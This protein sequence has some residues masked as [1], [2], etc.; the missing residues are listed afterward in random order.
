MAQIIKLR[1]SSVSGQKPTNSNLELGELA[2]NTTDG[3]V[4]LAKSGS[5]QSVEELISTNASNTGSI[6]LSGSINLNGNQIISGTLSLTRGLNA[7]SLTGS[8]NYE[9]LTNVPTLVS[10]SSQISYSGLTEIPLGIVSGSSQIN[11][12][13]TTGYSTLTASYV[14]NAVSSSFA[15][16]SENAIT[17]SYVLNVVS[18]SFAQN[19]ENAVSSS[20]AQNSVTASYV[21]NAVSSSFTQNS[22]NAV[23]SSF[24][25]NSENAITASYVLNVVSSSFSTTA[26]NAV[27]ASYVLNAVS[28]SFTQNSENAVSSSFAQNSENAVS[29][30]FAQN[31]ENTVTA[32][33]A[34]TAKTA[35]NAATTGSNIFIGNQTISGSVSVTGNINASSLTGSI[36]YEN[37]TNVP[38][39]VSGSSQ[40]QITGTTGYSA[41]SSSISSSI[42]NL[43]SSLN[44]TDTL[45]S[46]RIATIES[47]YATTGSN[48]FIGDESISG[49]LNIT[50]NTY[51]NGFI[52]LSPINQTINTSISGAYIYSSGSLNDIFFTQNSDGV[53]NTVKLNWL[54]SNLYTG[55]LKGGLLSAT[56]GSTTFNVASGSGIIVNLNASL[57]DEPN[58][59]ITYVNW[60][61][62]TGQTL[63]YLLSDIQTYIG[64]DVN[65]QI[66]Q[67]NVAF[68][69]NTYN[70]TI[71][72]G[73]I[74]HQNKTT[75]NG[76]ITYPNLA[77]GYK[78]RT[79]DF[80]KAFGPLKLSGYDIIPSS[81]LGLTIGGGTAF[82]DGRN[83]QNNPNQPS[84]ITDTGTTV[85][86]IFRYYQSGSIFV[87]DTNNSLGYTSL[88]PTVYNNNGVL[89]TVP[90]NGNNLRYTI[91]KLFWY[92][93]SVT[94]AI[95]AYY[96]NKLYASISEASNNISYEQFEEVENTKQNAIFLGTVILAGNADFNTQTSYLIL[97][98]GIFRSVVAGGGT[99]PTSNLSDLIDVFITGSLNGDLLLYDGISGEWKNGKILNGDYEISGSLNVTNG[100]T[101]SLYGTASFATNAQNATTASYVLNAVSSSFSQNSENAV[102]ASYVLNAVSSSFATTAQNA[103][104]ASYVLNAVSSSFSQNAVS[105]SFAQN[106]QNATT[107]SY[108]LNAVSSS[109]STNAQNALSS[110]FATT[111]TTAS[112]ATNTQ[113]ATTASYVL[114]AISSSFATNAT[115]A[116]Y[117]LNAVSSSF[118]QNATT[119]SYVLNAISSSFSQNAVS[120]SFAQN[121]QNATTASY[122]LN[123]VSSSF[124]TTA[125][126]A[127]TASYVLNAVSSSFATTAQ[128]ATTASYVLN[129]VSSSF[130]LNSQNATTASFVLNAVSSSFAQNATSASFAQNARTASYV[131]N[132]V[133]SSFATNSQNAITASYVLNAVS[134]SFATNS[135]NAITAS[136]ILNAISSSFATTAQNA[137]TA[138][139][140]LNAVS[141]SFAQNATSSSFAQNART[142]SYVLNAVSSSFATTAQNATTASYILNA[143]SSS[144]ATNAQ[145]ATTASYILNAVSSSFA[146]NSVSSSFAQNART[147]SYVLNAVSSSFATTAQN[148][149]TASYILNAVS[150]SFAQNATTASYILNAIS[151]SF[152]I[153]A[154]TALNAATTGSNTFIGNQV[155]SGSATFRDDIVVNGNVGI[156]T[157]SISEKLTIGTGDVNH[158]ILIRGTVA[159]VEFGNDT[160]GLKIGTVNN[161]NIYFTTNA[162]ERL[163]I[164][165]LGNVGIGTTD[166]VS[167][168]HVAG[169]IA[170][171]NGNML[172]LSANNPTFNHIKRDTT[173]G[174]I[175]IVA[176]S[177]VIF[178]KDN[179][180]VGIG[181]DSPTYK[182]DIVDPTGIVLRHSETTNTSGAFRIMGGSYTGNDMT[183]LM[184]NAVSGTNQLN[185]GGGTAL[186][187]PAT[188]HRFNVGA[189][190]TKGTGTEVMNI[191][192]NGI[193]VTGTGSFTTIDTGLGATEVHLMNQNVRTTDSVTF[194]NI[195][196][197]LSGNATTATTL[198]TART[199]NGTSFNGSANIVIPNLVSGSSQIVY[200][201]ISS[202]PAGIVSGS[203]QINADTITNFDANV[204]AYNNSLGVVSGSRVVTIGSTA[205]TLGGTA[206][207]IAGLISVT[208]TG[209]TGS[210]SGNATTATTLQTARTIGLSGVTA[211]ATSFN[212]SANIT[213]PITAVPTSLLT[214]IIAD[215]QISGSYTG[216]VNLTGTGTVDFN[217]FTG[218]ASN[219]VT[220]PSFTFTSDP[221]TG[222]YN[223][224]ADQ[225]GITTGGV[226]R[227]TIST[228]AISS[229]LPL[230]AT[231]IDTGQGATEVHL[232]NQNVRT[233]DSPTFNVLTV[234]TINSG[235]GATE[236]HLMNQNVRTTDSV[237]FAG[238]TE[239]SALKYKENIFSIEDTLD[240]VLKLRPVKYNIKGEEK[241]EIGLIAEEVHELIPELIKYN[242]ENEIDSI[243]YTRLAAVLIGAIKEQ[244]IQINKLKEQIEIN[245][246]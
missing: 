10:G 132:A 18:S 106:S 167:R 189:Y 104:T 232:M 38:T 235:Q 193:T 31:S 174:G 141:S 51:T 13:D 154:R 207:T 41:F 8:I 242:S 203:S 208:S 54:E 165:N 115:T 5:S 120:S 148:A 198:Q 78:Q 27:T 48:T 239:T 11:I 219:T 192:S 168:L 77:Y 204:L 244:Q 85:S 109:F 71:T 190:G 116:S 64:I 76:S 101:S 222:M 178:F 3:K 233:T 1:R 112:F 19:S 121:S 241:V 151:S 246:K 231:T 153:T 196:G 28:S 21:L 74:L 93:N 114:N 194:A 125:Q 25:Q 180:N 134:S 69:D 161:G 98:G 175:A 228:T 45:L 23:S 156:G 44:N 128:N 30:S 49:S 205:I 146:Q 75:I 52:N 179:G 43:S 240:T 20:F 155:I 70:T 81:S 102:T 182:L 212:G 46:G 158:K 237:S 63:I 177:Y 4:F 124:A 55:L 185:Y 214:G 123:A 230:S 224:G 221:N 137:T 245:K 129:A 172:S 152:A 111:S 103:T 159:D 99:I 32:S 145:N 227:L 206:T 183:G 187:E 73:T 2:I 225:V 143:V 216:M 163:R 79:Y 186:A 218:N 34:I 147:A 67:Q 188:I 87:Q 47:R 108:V 95:V 236:V 24:A 199:I 119:A 97:P 173:N 144:F 37:L 6:N 72:L 136:Y 149:T 26:Q 82:A 96:G 53:A 7:S 215:A 126:N 131:L 176:N 61:N 80:I 122:V 181:T 201:S 184:F 86:K 88:D 234:G 17:A 40:I 127:T 166:P 226:N 195:T 59:E 133:S 42:S 197:S 91:Q 83:Y 39:L 170:I 238:I 12:A 35:L 164:S 110:S 202:I 94:K 65:G 68:S 162:T 139:Y 142:A 113:N 209:F 138:S 84:F 171:S 92:P 33:F 56:S 15:Q 105:S 213:I 135:Q 118:A 29:S 140:V 50:G 200:G 157:T 210:L 160:L 191:N 229:S 57:N 90:T 62:F 130:A 66:T 169:D 107:A 217:K 223:P 89:T 100:I 220:S 60:G 22:E 14:L 9:N 150:S 117:I 211:T 243:S 16:N 58:P 36:N